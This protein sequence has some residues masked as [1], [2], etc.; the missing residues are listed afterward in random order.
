MATALSPPD[1]P[2]PL[3][4]RA[5]YDC[6]QSD[7]LD[8][9]KR[10]L[11]SAVVGGTTSAITGGKFVNGARSAAIGHLLNQEASAAERRKSITKEE[12]ENWT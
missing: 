12:Y 2:K 11:V 9:A 6:S 4:W 5:N 1:L 8:I 3:W 10:T 7:A